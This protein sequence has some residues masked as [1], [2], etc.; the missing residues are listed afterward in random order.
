MKIYENAAAAITGNPVT[1]LLTG[2][3]LPLAQAPSYRIFVDDGPWLAEWT[4]P[5]FSP[6]KVPMPGKG[7][8]SPLE[9]A[10]ARAVPNNPTLAPPQQCDAPRQP[11]EAER[12]VQPPLAGRPAQA[13]APAEPQR[14]REEEPGPP[15]PAQVVP[16]EP[17]QADPQNVDLPRRVSTIAPAWL[18][19]AR[20][21]PSV[22]FAG[23]AVVTWSAASAAMYA[24]SLALPWSVAPFAFWAVPVVALHLTTVAARAVTRSSGREDCEER[25]GRAPT[26]VHRLSRWPNRAFLGGEASATAGALLSACGVFAPWTLPLTAPV[27][28]GLGLAIGRQVG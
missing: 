14:P 12:P 7:G 24:A 23:L 5:Y 4:G 8:F 9:R 21:R 16:N 20:R 10:Q 11:R 27:T 28:V 1:S 6:E 22:A 18:L 2:R 25:G 26:L 13:P 15:E 17:L 3:C 19:R